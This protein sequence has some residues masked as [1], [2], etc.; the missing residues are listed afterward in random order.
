MDNEKCN[1]RGLD[2][3]AIPRC[4]KVQHIK[5]IANVLSDSVSRLRAVGLCH[6]LD[7]K[8]HQQEFSSPFEP[9][10]SVEQVTDM[11]IQ[12][13]KI[14]IAPHIEKLATNYDAL[15]DLPTVQTDNAN[16]SRK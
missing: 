13:N 9:L 3:A 10:H 4:I 6:I 2:T 7:S 5:E 1:T 8:D 16:L 15:C 11:S 12:I 14:L